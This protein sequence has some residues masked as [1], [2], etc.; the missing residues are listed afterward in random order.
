MKVLLW[1]PE[2][3]VAIPLRVA[4]LDLE[5]SSVR[6]TDSTDSKLPIFGVI[7]VLESSKVELDLEFASV[8]LQHRLAFF[9]QLQL[10]RLR[11]DLAAPIEICS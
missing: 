4:C 5:V 7:A 8:P 11:T 2:Q 6:V 1:D 3:L 10:A 9:G